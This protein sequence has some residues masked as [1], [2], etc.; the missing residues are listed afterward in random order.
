MKQLG[1]SPLQTFRVSRPGDAYLHRATE[2]FGMRRGGRQGHFLAGVVCATTGLGLCG[3]G[4][5]MAVA[6]RHPVA[7]QV[8]FFIAIVVPFTIFLTVLMVPRI[9]LSERLLSLS[10]ACIPPWSTACPVH[11]CWPGTTSISTSSRS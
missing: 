1:Y 3:E 6:P 2:A 5:A 4:L 11:S 8:L 10:S 7:G 9:G